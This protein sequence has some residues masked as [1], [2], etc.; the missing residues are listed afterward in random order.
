MF[1]IKQHLLNDILPPVPRD[2]FVLNIRSGLQ[3]VTFYCI[4]LYIPQYHQWTQADG[5]D[6]DHRYQVLLASL[7][8]TNV[9]LS[10]VQI[11]VGRSP[12]VSFTVLLTAPEIR[13]LM[14]RDLMGVAE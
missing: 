12:T 5:E 11:A 14:R 8:L 13:M 10:F 9:Q 6:G 4:T 3:R 7:L 2:F 1:K